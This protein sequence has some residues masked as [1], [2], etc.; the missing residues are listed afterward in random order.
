[1]D[2]RLIS[3]IFN[4]KHFPMNLC[5]RHF[6]LSV[7]IV[8]MP[9]RVLSQDISNFSYKLV[10]EKIEISYNLSGQSSD[11]YKVE[12]FNSLDNYTA[13]MKFVSGD[14]GDEI[15]PGK[16][17]KIVWEAKKELGEFKGGLA[18]RLK[19]EFIPFINFNIPQGDKFI[20]GKENIITWQGSATSDLKLELYRNQK[21]IADIG[22]V[23]DGNQ[24]NWNPPKKSFEKG[25]SYSIKGTANGR[26]AISKQFTLKNKLPI[27][28][29]VIPVVVVGGVVAILSGGSDSK[30]TEDNTIP[31]PLGPD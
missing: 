6:S 20:M 30:T 25:S 27:Y 24:Y 22:K 15:I 23:K 11:R 9:L 16:N 28:V 12:L 18:L 14:V 1:M 26:T 31:E 5:F 29:L 8:L 13:A 7:L 2:R 4:I 10:G 3:L 19:T 17:K 21:K